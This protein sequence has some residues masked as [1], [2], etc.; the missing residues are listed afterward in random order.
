MAKRMKLCMFC[1]KDKS[2]GRMSMEHF[3]PKG[4]WDGPLPQYVKTCPAHASCNG[5]FAN[6]N[7]YFRDVLVAEAGARAHLEVE[8]LYTG[9]MRRKLKNQPGSIR[10][11]FDDIAIRPVFTASSGLYIGNEP[12]FKVDWVR[13]KRVILNVMRGINYTTQKQPLPLAWKVGILRDEEI[14]HD[15]LQG[16]FSKM[17][18]QWQTFG[19]DVF[20]CRYVFHDEAMA[21]L[22]QFYRRRTFFGWAWSDEFLAAQQA[23]IMQSML[24]NPQ[25]I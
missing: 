7:E 8:K 6:D 23:R 4:L 2:L 25:S 13:V 9:K 22:M 16:L 11:V 24:L 12:T 14:D 18:P 3:V 15:G 17:T 19:D 21:C 10:K 5:A 20:G 1:G